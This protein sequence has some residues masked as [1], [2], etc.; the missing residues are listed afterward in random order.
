MRALPAKEQVMILS[1]KVEFL[2]ADRKRMRHDSPCL[3]LVARA[4]AFD[5]VFRAAG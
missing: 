5:R 4:W 1:T 2:K 3:W